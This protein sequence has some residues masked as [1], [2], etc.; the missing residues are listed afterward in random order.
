MGIFNIDYR[1]LVN[2]YVRKE[3]NISFE[4]CQCFLTI[5]AN[6]PQEQKLLDKKS[7][8]IVE[9]I[10]LLMT[11]FEILPLLILQKNWV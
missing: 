6:R 4:K 10:M 9:I 5:K 2:D 8:Y 3:L 11:I 7:F 1:L